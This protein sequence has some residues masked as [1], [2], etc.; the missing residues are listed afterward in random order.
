MAINMPIPICRIIYIYIY[1]NGIILELAYFQKEIFHL[2]EFGGCK[3]MEFLMGK[4]LSTA[5]FHHFFFV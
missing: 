2:W 1:I 5:M 4:E 3:N